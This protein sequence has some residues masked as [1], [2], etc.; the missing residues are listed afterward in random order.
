MLQT[1]P[2]LPAWAIGFILL[3]VFSA[4][5]TYIIRFAPRFTEEGKTGLLADWWRWINRPS[6]QDYKKRVYTPKQTIDR[7]V[8]SWSCPICGSDLSPNDV[9]QM[10]LRYNIECAYCGATLGSS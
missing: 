4:S 8:E 7:Q 10:E 1:E 3:V 6:S 2:S 9:E 5:I